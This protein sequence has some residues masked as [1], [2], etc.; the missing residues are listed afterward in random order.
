MTRKKKSLVEKV[1]DVLTK[2]KEIKEVEDVVETSKEVFYDELGNIIDLD[3]HEEFGIDNVG[4][5]EGDGNE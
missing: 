1:K 3:S 5:D 2:D 4:E